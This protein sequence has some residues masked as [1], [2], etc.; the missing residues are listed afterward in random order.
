MRLK[1]SAIHLPGCVCVFSVHIYCVCVSLCLCERVCVCV[2]CVQKCVDVCACIL[3]P[4]FLVS[5]PQTARRTNAYNLCLLNIL[6]RL[7]APP[8]SLSSSS[9]SPL[10]C[11]PPPIRTLWDIAPPQDIVFFSFNSLIVV[12]R[13]AWL[14][15]RTELE[16]GGEEEGRRGG[17]SPPLLQ[18]SRPMADVLIAASRFEAGYAQKWLR[19]CVCVCV[20]VRVYVYVYLIPGS[21]FLRSRTNILIYKL[22]HV[23]LWNAKLYTQILLLS[24]SFINLPSCDT[25]NRWCSYAA[26]RQAGE[27]IIWANDAIGKKF[28]LANRFLKIER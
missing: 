20:C 27:L 13:S 15:I 14:F 17:G 25:L 4:C 1:V 7:M 18:G 16:G 19:A 6:A 11:P 26:G 24:V 3:A 12:S 10:P 8:L 5:R 9:P 2:C 23:K 22:W 28:P 21:L